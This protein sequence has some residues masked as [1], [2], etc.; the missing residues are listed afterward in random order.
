MKI[1]SVCTSIS[2]AILAALLLCSPA[3][4]ADQAS[5]WKVGAGYQAM[6]AGEFLNGISARAWYQDRFGIEGN[7]F[8][9]GVDFE[10]SSDWDD[11]REEADLY[12]GEIKLMYAPIV[13][14]YSKFYI[15]AQGSIGQFELDGDLIDYKDEIYGFGVF[16]GSE[17]HFQEIPELGFNFDVGYK[18]YFYEDKPYGSS[19]PEVDIELKGVGATFG[20]H[21]YF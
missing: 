17:F 16:I 19:G 21:Y 10:V 7:F 18:H 3:L 2:T 9:G 14:E 4:A 20:I 8:Y 5:D 12:V 6:W 11:M 13:R 1:N 15:G